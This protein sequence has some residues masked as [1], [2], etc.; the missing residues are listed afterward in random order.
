MYNNLQTN[1][2]IIVQTAVQMVEMLVSEM[3]AD[4]IASW[5]GHIIKVHLGELVYSD[6]CPHGSSIIKGHPNYKV[7]D[8]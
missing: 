4:N 2:S 6:P 3:K 8:L 1:W 5:V 7:Q